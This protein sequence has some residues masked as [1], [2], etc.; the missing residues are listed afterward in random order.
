MATK[1]DGYVVVYITPTYFYSEQ[2]LSNGKDQSSSAIRSGT[3]GTTFLRIVCLTYIILAYISTHTDYNYD[4]LL[5]FCFLSAFSLSDGAIK[6]T[7]R[8]F[9]T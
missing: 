8:L 5:S 1:G 3:L 9:T 4:P 2:S 7:C 6:Q